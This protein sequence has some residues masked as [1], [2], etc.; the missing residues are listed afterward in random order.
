MWTQKWKDCVAILYAHHITVRV[1]DPLV[2]SAFLLTYQ[3][4]QRS[5]IKLNQRTGG[6]VTTWVTVNPPLSKPDHF[7]WCMHYSCMKWCLG[8]FFSKDYSSSLKIT[9]GLHR[10]SY[11][12]TACIT[13]TINSS[14]L[15]SNEIVTRQTWCILYI[16]GNFRNSYL[17]FELNVW[18]VRQY[19]VQFS[20]Y[21]Q[22]SREQIHTIAITGVYK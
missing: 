15:S 13:R 5:S 12:Q 2:C 20:V 4:L 21:S 3:R 1:T 19:S 18:F 11:P 22:S 9:S 8:A 7:I 14:S 16:P 6:I 17:L 10:S